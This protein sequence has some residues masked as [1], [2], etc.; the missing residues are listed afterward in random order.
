MNINHKSEKDELD[1]INDLFIIPIGYENNLDE[2]TECDNYLHFADIE[3]NMY[4][5]GSKIWCLELPETF[6]IAEKAGNS[7][8]HYQTLR[9]PSGERYMPLFTSY[10][11]MT[12]IFG[13]KIQVGVIS[14][15]TA[16]KFCID[17]GFEG[18]VVAP[19]ILNKIISKEELS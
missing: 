10:N 7:L 17:E 2:P 9:K 12:S 4:K 16:K 19:G 13:S 14:F 15:E 5:N 8:I 3:A 18:I 6:S 11:S 1:I